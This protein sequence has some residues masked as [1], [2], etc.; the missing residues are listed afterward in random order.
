M[1]SHELMLISVYP[2]ML[3]D[4]QAVCQTMH[5]E[6]TILQW[7]IAQQGLLDKLNQMFWNC[8]SPMSLSAAGPPQA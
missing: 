2:E 7:E 5:I 3:E 6:P 1:K 8:L 4:I